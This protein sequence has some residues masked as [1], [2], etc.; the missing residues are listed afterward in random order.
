V[1]FFFSKRRIQAV[2]PKV[3]TFECRKALP[4]AWRGVRDAE[5]STL[6]GIP[7]CIFVRTQH[8]MEPGTG[9]L[10]FFFFDLVD[11]SGFIGGNQTYE[12]ALEMAR[13]SL[14]LA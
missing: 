3:D 8:E 10:I 12:G 13:Q 5:L 4:Q 1:F 14:T 6:S 7:N 11:A 2:P 9:I